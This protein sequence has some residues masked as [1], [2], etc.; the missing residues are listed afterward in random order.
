M[1]VSCDR[2][3]AAVQHHGLVRQHVGLADR[4]PPTVGIG[5][6]P[7]KER[8]QLCDRLADKPIKRLPEVAHDVGATQRTTGGEQQKRDGLK[9][10]QRGRMAAA[11]A[12]PYARLALWV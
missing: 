4:R 6:Q 12:R 5:L 3:S 11:A 7:A 1:D 8:R 10:A 9:V 2:V